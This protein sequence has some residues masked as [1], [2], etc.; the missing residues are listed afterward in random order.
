MQLLL[1][2]HK[3]SPSFEMVFEMVFYSLSGK[4]KVL[5]G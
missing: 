4:L 1:P 2:T 3:D 5:A